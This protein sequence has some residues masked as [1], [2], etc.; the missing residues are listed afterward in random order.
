MLL[1]GPW[2]LGVGRGLLVESPLLDM[3]VL[4]PTMG[5][6]ALAGVGGGGWVSP[7]QGSPPLAQLFGR[8]CQ[9]AKLLPYKDLG[10]HRVRFPPR[11][12]GGQSRGRVPDLWEGSA[13]FSDPGLTSHWELRK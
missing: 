6:Q 2:L 3:V 10:L 8:S 9:V 7:P 13:P 4:S 12:P 11:G 5:M 1:E